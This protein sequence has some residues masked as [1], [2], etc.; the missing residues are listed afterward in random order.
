MAQL[1]MQ[2]RPENNG[3]RFQSSCEDYV[4]VSP[5]CTTK[6]GKSSMTSLNFKIS[7]TYISG[8]LMYCSIARHVGMLV[9]SM[10]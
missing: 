4:T 3:G 10:L 8:E 6:I 7:S 1:F 2:C 9:W 5:S